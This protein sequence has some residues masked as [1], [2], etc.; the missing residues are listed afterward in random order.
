MSSKRWRL[1]KVKGLAVE[2]RSLRGCWRGHGRVKDMVASLSSNGDG[3]NGERPRSSNAPEMVSGLVVG[4][5]R[6]CFEAD[7]GESVVLSLVAAK[8]WWTPA[9]SQL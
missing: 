1:R 2:V 6:G 7:R 9:H 5:A 8:P 3:L 4:K